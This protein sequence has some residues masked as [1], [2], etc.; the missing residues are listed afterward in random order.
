MTAVYRKG[1]ANR[2]GS[3]Y[4]NFYGLMSDKKLEWLR[5]ERSTGKGRSCWELGCRN[6]VEGISEE[7]PREKRGRSVGRAKM[8]LA[9][10]GT[11]TTSSVGRG[12]LGAT[13]EAA[14]GSN[15]FFRISCLVRLMSLWPVNCRESW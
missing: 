15:G 11:S 5:K 2:R 4:Q 6:K 13:V 9:T 3:K 7:G 1:I 14:G 8:Q 12:N 10:V